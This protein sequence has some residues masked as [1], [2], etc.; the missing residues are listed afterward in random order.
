MQPRQSGTP[1]INMVAT[2]S[3]AQQE[4]IVTNLLKDLTEMAKT[5]NYEAANNIINKLNDTLSSYQKLFQNVK[6]SRETQDDVVALIKE[7]KVV[8]SKFNVAFDK[9]ALATQEI[10]AIY[11]AKKNKID[12]LPDTLKTQLPVDIYT[13]IVSF[14]QK[15]GSFKQQV[16]KYYKSAEEVHNKLVELAV[17]LKEQNE[18]RN[19][20]QVQPANGNVPNFL[21][22][23]QGSQQRAALANAN[24]NQPNPNVRNNPNSNQ[25]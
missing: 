22:S 10:T 6:I 20:A 16:D 9:F 24:A 1:K 13:R 8:S 7:K 21:H 15:V 19:P 17:T 11:N 5:P 4:E 23:N 3:R 2:E 25:K 18:N 12:P 14:R